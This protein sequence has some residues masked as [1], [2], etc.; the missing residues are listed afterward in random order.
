MCADAD[1]LM[2]CCA[3]AD[4]VLCCAVLATQNWQNECLSIKK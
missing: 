2:L 3:D 1:M 4:A